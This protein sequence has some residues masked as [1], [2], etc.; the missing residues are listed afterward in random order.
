MYQT[1]EPTKDLYQRVLICSCGTYISDGKKKSKCD[2]YN[3]KILKTGIIID[4]PSIIKKD[5]DKYIQNEDICADKKSRKDIESNIHLLKIGQDYQVN[6]YN[7]VSLINYNLRKLQYKPFFPDKE[8]V[9]SLIKRLDSKPDDI[10]KIVVFPTKSKTKCKP[11]SKSKKTINKYT[12]DIINS[13]YYN[14][15]DV[16]EESD[17]SDD[18]ENY[19]ENENYVS[20]IDYDTFDEEYNEEEAFSD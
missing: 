3:K 9:D 17:N 7:Y 19:N 13:Y 1:L 20:D 2:F 15:I 18:N 14:F 11:K 10:R 16:S 8:S 4:N 5:Y 12:Q 6:I